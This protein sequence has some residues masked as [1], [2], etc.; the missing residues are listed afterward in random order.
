MK[1]KNH[2]TYPILFGLHER[3]E[4]E[5]IHVLYYYD[6]DQLPYLVSTK[7]VFFDEIH[8][9]KSCGLPT[10]SW[11][12]EYIVSFTRYKEVKVDV[13]SGIYHMNNSPKKQRFS[14][15]RNEDSV[16]AYKRLKFWMGK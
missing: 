1:T 14:M 13:E 8:I 9:Q 15:R 5:I 2:F 7:L 11:L 16:L 10:T 3:E 6:K 4:I 12:N